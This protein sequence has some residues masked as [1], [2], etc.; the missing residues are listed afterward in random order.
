MTNLLFK[1]KILFLGA[2]YAQLPII[3]EA[4]RN[5]YYIITCDY[6]PQNPGHKIA[7]EYY[8]VSTTDVEKIYQLAKKLRI[9]YIINY[10]SDPSAIT[11]AF[12]AEKLGLPGNTYESVGLLTNKDLF[13]Q[14]LKD[15]GFIVP[16]F[17]SFGERDNPKE[18]VK[19][20]DFPLIV[21]PVDS[22]GSKGVS[23]VED[24]HG[25]KKAVDKAFMFS[26]TKKL[27]VEE[28]IDNKGADL[29]G[30]G[31]VVDGELVFI[32][33]GDHIFDEN[34]L[35]PV[36][37]LW[38]T[39]LSE[40]LIDEIIVQLGTIIKRSG[41]KNGPVNIEVRVNSKG[42]NYI[43]EI[44]PRN[45][46]NFVPQ[47]IQYSTGFDFVQA[48]I[49][50]STG[51]KPEI[52]KKYDQL[53]AAYYVIHSNEYGFLKNVIIKNDLKKYIKEFHQYIEPGEKVMPFRGSNTAIG[54]IVMVFNQY[55]EMLKV[56]TNINDY[57][58][59]KVEKE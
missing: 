13:R 26:K 40:K 28:F 33:L 18:K 31:F 59:V 11:A 3:R 23:R 22:S 20:L 38:P 32:S 19:D 51:N 57:I 9:D 12:V 48:L 54:V 42:E 5:G 1:E 45:G 43:M 2:S 50:V 35:T 47:V 44:G 34:S 10:V 56:I 39:S 30:D 15:L 46:G 14:L 36:S 52:P 24:I 41:Y 17:V 6:L 16:K 49:A 58:E 25:L 27:I 55:S 4:K 21:K 29:H 53:P 7:N 37:T 8:N